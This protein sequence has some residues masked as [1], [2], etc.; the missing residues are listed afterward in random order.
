MPIMATTSEL[1]DSTKRW[2]VFQNWILLARTKQGGILTQ[3][4]YGVL[5]T[6]F[7]RFRE[8]ASS[9]LF[10]WAWGSMAVL[11]L[12]V[13]EEGVNVSQASRDS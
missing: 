10:G 4:Q 8:P 1:I 5:E 12:A 3:Q 2:A 7:L 6:E 13:R 11:H 9:P